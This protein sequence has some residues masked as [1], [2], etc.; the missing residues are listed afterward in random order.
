LQAT[1]ACCVSVVRN[2]C[3]DHFSRKKANGQSVEHKLS[4]YLPERASKKNKKDGLYYMYSY[5]SDIA[6]D[7]RRTIRIK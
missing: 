4:S 1:S 2:E 3:R 7:P 6:R 5:Y